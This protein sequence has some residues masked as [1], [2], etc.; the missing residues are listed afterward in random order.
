[1]SH[2]LAHTIWARPYERPRVLVTMFFPAAMAA[3]GDVFAH[4]IQIAASAMA[5][6]GHACLTNTR[7][8]SMDQARTKACVYAIQNNYTH[9]L[10]LDA[11]HKH[12]ADI[13]W[14]LLVHNKDVVCGLN[15]MRQHPHK[16]CASKDVHV[17]GQLESGR[18]HAI[19][20]P[21]IQNT[22]L[23]KVEGAGS[24][25]IMIRLSCLK[26]LKQPWFYFPYHDIDFNDLDQP[27]AGED[28][29]FSTK[30]LRA[31]VELWCDTD[32]TSP[33]LGNLW[34]DKT[35]VESDKPL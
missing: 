1:M 5:T 24:G 20:V 6:P 8:G 17:V 2:T 22:G 11:D 27:W 21:P 10:M 16:A 30:C 12:P 28:G 33:H 23:Q 19:H 32:L 4:Y 15:F 25:C 18:A 31:G 35:E 9:V 14:R 7:S 26:K 3:P 29:G 34:V 13:V